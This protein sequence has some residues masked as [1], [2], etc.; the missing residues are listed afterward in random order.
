MLRIIFVFFVLIL[1]FQ[2]AKK[3]YQ[4]N[5]NTRQTHNETV[6]SRTRMVQKHADW[7]IRRSNLQRKR[8]R[9]DRVA[10]HMNKKA[11]KYSKKLVK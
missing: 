3:P 11:E 8:A 7:E 9:K 10:R 5:Y 4:P 1:G 6:K 2:C